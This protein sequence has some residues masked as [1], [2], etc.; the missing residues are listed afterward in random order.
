MKFG[1]LRVFRKSGD[2]IQVSL[3]LTR[4]TGT[5]REDQNRICKENQKTH[6]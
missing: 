6:L 1:V 5:L 3:K 2:K 4:A